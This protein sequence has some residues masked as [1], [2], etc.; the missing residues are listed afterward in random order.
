MG[1]NFWIRRCK[2]ADGRLLGESVEGLDLGVWQMGVAGCGG[3]AGLELS[4]CTRGFY[5][6]TFKGNLCVQL[7]SCGQPYII[8]LVDCSHLEFEP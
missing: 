7:S 8:L 1:E 3:M 4:V 6:L 5:I 2:G